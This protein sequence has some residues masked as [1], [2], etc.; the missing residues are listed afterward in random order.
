M[1]QVF[2]L[3]GVARGPQQGVRHLEAH[4]E[5][6]KENTRQKFKVHQR[7]C[8]INICSIN[9]VH[10]CWLFI[11]HILLIIVLVIVDDVWIRN[12]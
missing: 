1:A 9:M 12:G 4:L 7:E 3:S 6:K 10:N 5:G 8:S 11:V 2:E